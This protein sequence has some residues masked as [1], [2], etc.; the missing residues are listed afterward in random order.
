MFSMSSRK[1]VNW[2]FLSEFKFSEAKRHTCAKDSVRLS[3]RILETWKITDPWLNDHGLF[4]APIMDSISHPSVW[5]NI[6]L[7]IK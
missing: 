1:S 7:I 6:L 3:F 5:P 4:L 2:E